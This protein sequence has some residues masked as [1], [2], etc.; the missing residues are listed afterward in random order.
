MSGLSAESGRYLLRAARHAI[1][2]HLGV[3]GEAPGI[4]AAELQEARAAR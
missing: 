3:E 1:A 2:T 4:P